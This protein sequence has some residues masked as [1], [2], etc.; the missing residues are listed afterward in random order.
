MGRGQLLFKGD[1]K[2]KSKKKSKSG[3]V[4][5]SP[6]G[7]S[8]S[9]AAFSSSASSAAH[10]DNPAVP[11][12]STNSNSNSSRQQ[13]QQVPTIQVG[14]GKITTSGTVVMGH[15]TI[16]EKQLSA[17]DALLV[18]IPGNEAGG[19]EEEMRVITMRLSNTSCNLSSGFTTSI[20]VPTSFRYIKKTKNPSKK[21]QDKLAKAKL[22]QHEREMHA[23]G[24]TYASNTE[25]VYRE[26]TETG[27]YRI[28][29]ESGGD[30]GGTTRSRGE[31]L[32]L[33]SKKS[34]DKYC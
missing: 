25:I 10:T 27:S 4:K 15:N 1:K 32:Q 14:K 18:R 22:S 12:T 7:T 2:K 6:P 23:F 8:S 28:K 34:S 26:K 11:T 21:K 9:T 20:K 33:R 30:S 5:H 19:G 24:G 16:F 31:L 17:G 13:K 3:D 29:R